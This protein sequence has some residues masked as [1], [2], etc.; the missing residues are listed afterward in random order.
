MNSLTELLDDYPNVE[1]VGRPKLDRELLQ[2]R[3]GHASAGA[4]SRPR[5]EKDP[6]PGPLMQLAPRLPPF[7]DVPNEDCAPLDSYLDSD[8]EADAGWDLLNHHVLPLTLIAQPSSDEIIFR[9]DLD[10]EK[11]F[12]FSE[13]ESYGSRAD[14]AE[15]GSRSEVHILTNDSN[16]TDEPSISTRYNNYEVQRSRASDLRY[17]SQSNSVMQF[18]GTNAQPAAPSSLRQQPHTHPS[19]SDSDHHHTLHEAIRKLEEASHLHVNE[20]PSVPAES[21]VAPGAQVER[22][23]DLFEQ[24]MR[25][26][27]MYIS[28][29]DQYR[30][31]LHGPSHHQDEDVH[32]DIS[33]EQHL[34]VKKDPNSTVNQDTTQPFRPPEPTGPA[35]P[36]SSC[37][38]YSAFIPTRVPTLKLDFPSTDSGASQTSLRNPVMKHDQGAGRADGT[39]G[40]TKGPITN[41][42]AAFDVASLDGL[43]ARL[44]R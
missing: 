21:S 13:L 35:T 30:K 17:Q 5:I 41:A 14:G 37:P 16:D 44:A 12:A 28:I 26:A 25:E 42:L 22:L 27:D 23:E 2:M 43:L 33:D 19:N 11:R 9:T 4:L 31:T 8:A 10:P 29:Y 15:A 18:S 39:D 20:P 24:T 6:S 40:L 1:E 7:N 3:F 32:V 34:N 38:T 36:S